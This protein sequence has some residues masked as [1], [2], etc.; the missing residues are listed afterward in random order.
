MNKKIVKNRLYSNC[1]KSSI[2]EEYIKVCFSMYRSLHRLPFFVVLLLINTACQTQG[3]G[4]VQK[5]S[6]EVTT[7]PL[8]EMNLDDLTAFRSPGDN[9][10]ITG[11]VQSDYQTEYSMEVTDGTGILVNPDMDHTGENM[12]TEIE[13][14]DIELKIEFLVPKGSN[15]GIYLQG[16]YEVQILDSWNISEPRFSDVGGIYERW[17]DSKLEGEKGYE[18]FPPKINAGIAP[19]LW[20]EY[21]ILFRAPRFDD[22][23]NKTENAR[24]E[25]VY[26][27]G[28]LIHE[29]VEVTGPTRAS[30]FTE[31]VEEAPIMLQGDHGPVAFRN[32]RYKAFN[33]T[34][35]ITL[36]Q[37]NYTVYDYQGNR[38]PVD[39][40]NLEIIAEGV[41]DHFNISELS[42]QNEHY[43][44]V[45]SS[46][47]EV[48]VTGDYLFETQMN[49]AG[50]LYINGELVIENTGK[51]N[52]Q[53]Q[54]NIIHL[55]QGTHQIKVTHLQIV[56]STS[57]M[58]NYEGPNIEKRPLVGQPAVSGGSTQPPVTVQPAGT[59]PEII[60]GFTNYGGKKRTHTVS[61][62]DP[63][64]IH[65]SYDLNNASLLKFW[66]DPFA[67]VTRMWRG[68]GHEQLLV[69][70]NAAIEE[71]S[72]FALASS[73]TDELFSEQSL[74]HENG[75]SR[76][77]FNEAG[78]PV[79][80]AELGN[81]ILQD[82]IAP[83]ESNT[84]F[85]RT[86]H[87]TSDQPLVEKVAR[88]AIGSS[89][90]PINNS[91]YRIDGRYYLDLIE[92]GGNAPEIAEHEG[93]QALIIPI[94]N[95]RNQSTI[96]YRFIW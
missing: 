51:I 26:L 29:N 39:F 12:F 64:G 7:L 92:D 15:S 79:F 42:P 71:T 47:F 54:G 30:E 28:V 43:A 87:Y 21:H 27:N 34:D 72:G 16:R 96:Q 36:D 66:R 41:T 75:V 49:N 53:R 95:D 61:V 82:H 63:G 18:G 84:E 76:Y 9:W 3:S 81:I 65:Y 22:A 4:D 46:N 6:E 67:D 60:G 48:P 10:L 13:H 56:W 94:L 14:G 19:G 50:N 57:L 20:Q 91:L 17:D 62:G 80:Y 38:M 58:V 89:I 23:G 88:L 93:N 1:H 85:I 45:F 37:M 78:Q 73:Q 70:I 52:N 69:P 74:L 83:S 44:T 25:K 8:H 40:E 32:I 24:F 68:R 90:D 86:L 11:N 35:S 5:G 59:Q 55:T 31:E 2:V 33:R 77:E